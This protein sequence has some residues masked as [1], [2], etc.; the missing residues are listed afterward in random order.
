MEF[1]IIKTCFDEFSRDNVMPLPN[2]KS[3]E[4][5]KLIEFCNKVRELETQ[6]GVK[7]M[8]IAS[9]TEE[10]EKKKAGR[11][12]EAFRAEFNKDLSHDNL[13]YFLLAVNYLEI[14]VLMMILSQCLAD[15]IKNKSVEYCRDLFGVKNDYTPAEEAKY[16]DLYAW[17]FEGPEIEEWKGQYCNSNR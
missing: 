8:D 10:G 7:Y 9:S 15:G 12:L 2:V 11:F 14:E 16:R 6:F 1:A 3:W 4:M 13:V 5:V 17:A